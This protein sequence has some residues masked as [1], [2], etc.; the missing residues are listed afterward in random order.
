MKHWYTFP[1][2]IRTYMERGVQLKS[3]RCWNVLIDLSYQQNI[4]SNF[5][6]FSIWLRVILLFI[7]SDKS[8]LLI[9]LSAN[10]TDQSNLDFCAT[11][12][13]SEVLTFFIWVDY[14]PEKGTTNQ[15]SSSLKYCTAFIFATWLVKIKTQYANT[16]FIHSSLEHDQ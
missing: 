12:G 7:G 3:G 4:N 5:M 16:K 13:I 2:K 14:M 11:E 6:K 15:L 1:L 8:L 9:W 10:Q